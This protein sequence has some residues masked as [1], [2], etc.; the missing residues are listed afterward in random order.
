MS[1]TIYIPNNFKYLFGKRDIKFHSDSFRCILMQS[2][3]MFDVDSHETLSD[4]SASELASGNG[5]LTGGQEV[6]RYLSPDLS[7]AYKWYR[8]DSLNAS[9]IKFLRTTWK[10][11]GG[12]IG[13]V[14][15][16]ILYDDTLTG[17]PIVCCLQLSSG[18]T[19]SDGYGITI[20]DIT[21]ALS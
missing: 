15:A 20:G 5:Y 8:D 6:G 18:V 2:G 9:N 1:T 10:A 16:A 14:Q 13:P 12:S 11:S 19:A 21:I 4:V 17:D 7:S 3:F